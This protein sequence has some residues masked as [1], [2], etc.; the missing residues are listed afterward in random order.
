MRIKHI[1]YRLPGF[2]KVAAYAYKFENMSN[3]ATFKFN[4]I[5]FADDHGIAAAAAH[6]QVSKR[7]VYR[8]MEQ[9][10]KFKIHG[11]KN[12]YVDMKRNYKKWDS[13]VIDQ[14]SELRTLHANLGARKIV[15][16]L[17]E[18]CAVNALKC[19]SRGTIERIIR[20]APDK[21]RTEVIGHKPKRVINR[22]PR[23]R[24]QSG[25]QALYPGHC[26]ALDTIVRIIDGNRTYITVA[27]DLYSRMALAIPGTSHKSSIPAKLLR[28][29]PGI[30]NF[31]IERVLT[32]NGSE[33][34]KDFADEVQKM[35]IKHVH[36]YPRTPKANAHCERFNRTLWEE[37]A[38]FHQH[39]LQRENMKEFNKLLLDWLF[40]Y[41]CKRPHLALGN[42]APVEVML[43]SSNC[44]FDLSH[45]LSLIC[46]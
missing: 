29:L 46:L 32:D 40:W 12:N 28:Q 7:T 20:S 17:A 2:Y 21:M 34:A 27:I 8:W 15:V 9:Y 42:A 41:N 19:P 3:T 43:K 24:K 11:L 4:T 14:I 25:F 18:F 30:F 39:L 26:V 10:E 37:F 38:R 1:G 36:T 5:L 35:K 33:F 23:E 22:A 16:L 45:T 13:R 31:K 44:H 6:A